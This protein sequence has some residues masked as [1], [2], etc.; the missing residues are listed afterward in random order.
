MWTSP[1][2]QWIESSSIQWAELYVEVIGNEPPQ[3]MVLLHY[4]AGN[5]TGI[6]VALKRGA[7]VKLPIEVLSSVITLV[8]VTQNN[9]KALIAIN[10]NLASD[11]VL[12]VYMV[13]NT[14]LAVGGSGEAR[15]AGTVTVDGVPASRD[16][17]VISDNKSGGRE[18]LASGTSAGDGTF[19]IQYTGWTGAV[20][21]LAMDEYGNAFV[22]S[23]P[24]NLGNIVHPTTPNG[25]VYQVT[26]AGT[27]GSTE[28]VW[29][30]SSNVISGGVT[31]APKPYYRPV[32]SGPLKA[33]V[34]SP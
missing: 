4:S 10:V 17:L 18:V 15:I 20:I 30:T 2:S 14:G 9:S 19:E 34:I 5:P 16:V 13:D 6:Q 23:T 27:T 3:N 24:I 11:I 7:P 31:F 29:S 26:V 28:P 1:P 32:A 21:A 22:P 25:Y 33:D 8:G 12:T